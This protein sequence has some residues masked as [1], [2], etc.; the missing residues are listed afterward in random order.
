[1]I[2]AL[3]ATAVLITGSATAY[4]PCDGSTSVMASGKFDALTLQKELRMP[5]E[6]ISILLDG[7]LFKVKK[8]KEFDYSKAWIPVESNGVGVPVF[9]RPPN[10]DA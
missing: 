2:A 7:T 10:S 3:A 8:I 1:M 5:L 4:H 9:E 6:E